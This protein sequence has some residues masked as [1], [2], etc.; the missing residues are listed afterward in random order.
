MVA[1]ALAAT[2]SGYLAVFLVGGLAVQ[3]SADLGFGVAR[4]GIMATV[5]FGASAASSIPA[6]WLAE[7]LG[8]R[9]AVM[10]AAALSALSLAAVATVGRSWGVLVMCLA[11]AGISNGTSQPAVNLL[12]ARGIA[13]ARQGLVFGIKQSAV[14]AASL[15]GGAAVPVVGLTIGWQWAFALAAL[16]PLMVMVLVPDVGAPVKRA[17]GAGLRVGDAPARALVALAI[18]AGLGTAAAS[19]LG[20]FLV[21]AAVDRGVA[22]SPAGVLL[23]IASGFGVAGRVFFGWRADL[24]GGRHLLPVGRMMLAGAVGFAVLSFAPSLPWLAVGAALGFGAGWGWNGVLTF[25]VVRTNPMAPAYATGVTQAGLYVGGMCGPVLFAL[26]AERWSFAAGWAMGA[27]LLLAAWVAVVI[28][29]RW[30]VAGPPAVE[31]ASV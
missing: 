18:A 5:F 31:T 13:S 22:E 7:R 8:T 3:I 21:T 15:L 2:T 17:P 1:T 19:T 28:G 27:L 20:T 14:P 30:T 4:L 6:G 10:F 12:L 11:V 29:E 25:A 26:V 23:A 9:R 16:L 24:G